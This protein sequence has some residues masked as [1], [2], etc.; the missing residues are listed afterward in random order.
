MILTDNEIIFNIPPV[1]SPQLGGKG[2]IRDFSPLFTNGSFAPYVDDGFNI[3]CLWTG[4]V[5]SLI[6]SAG[7]SLSPVSATT[8]L[9]QREVSLDDEG[10]RKRWTGKVGLDI[11]YST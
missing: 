1:F 11:A 8:G 4:R 6:V 10:R 5:K 7:F 2:R 3:G 9:L